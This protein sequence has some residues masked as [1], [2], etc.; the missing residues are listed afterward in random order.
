MDTLFT[1]KP[2]APLS[3]MILKLTGDPVSHTAIHHQGYVYHSN[4]KGVNRVP[5]KE[6]TDEYIIKLCLRP[7][8]ERFDDMMVSRLIRRFPLLGGTLY[9]IPALAYMGAR[10]FLK[11]VFGISIPKKNLW[12]VSGMYLCTEFVTDITSEE[13]DS[14]LTPYQLFGKMKQS[15][16]W[17]ERVAPE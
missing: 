13:V 12:Q 5:L 17:V 11:D 6:F 1:I 10:F 4:Y 2:G 7:T 16:K 3:K 15:G 9:D 14:E 8:D